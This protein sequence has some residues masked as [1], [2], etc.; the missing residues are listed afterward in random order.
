MDRQGKQLYN[1]AGSVIA[2]VDPTR[3]Y[4]YR[5]DGSAYGYVSGLGPL[6][7]VGRD[8]WL[9]QAG[10]PRVGLN[11]AAHLSAQLAAASGVT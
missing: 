5:L 4:M 1:E 7:P 10:I 2:N 11:L 8:H 9:L 3:M 6:C